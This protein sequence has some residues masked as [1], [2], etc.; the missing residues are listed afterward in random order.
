MV[1]TEYCLK[2]LVE[3]PRSRC[4]EGILGNLMS[5]YTRDNRVGVRSSLSYIEIERMFLGGFRCM[6]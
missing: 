5:P 1:Q 4:D 2:I 3:T 6:K